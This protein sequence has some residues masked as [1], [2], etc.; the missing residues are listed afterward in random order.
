VQREVGGQSNAY[1]TEE[2]DAADGDHE[3]D[4]NDKESKKQNRRSERAV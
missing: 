4:D 2:A 3:E 1:T